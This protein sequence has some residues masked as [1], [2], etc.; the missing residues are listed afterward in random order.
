MK[1]LAE[2]ERMRKLSEWLNTPEGRLRLKEA[3]SK[4]ESIIDKFV[5]AKRIDPKKLHEPVTI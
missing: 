3:L 5:G 2:E 1:N 4:T